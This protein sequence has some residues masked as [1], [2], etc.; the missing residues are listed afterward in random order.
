L[1]LRR[2]VGSD[3]AFATLLLLVAAV[4]NFLLGNVDFQLA[5]NLLIGSLPGVVL[6]SYLCRFLPENVLRPA[7]AGILIFAGLRLV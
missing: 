3:I 1:G 7:L 6:G 4:G 2:I 5:G